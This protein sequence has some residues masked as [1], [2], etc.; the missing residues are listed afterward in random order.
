[1]KNLYFKLILILTI[2]IAFAHEYHKNKEP[3]Q[4]QWL[5]VLPGI[6]ILVL[7]QSTG[8]IHNDTPQ[9]K[10]FPLDMLKK[11]MRVVK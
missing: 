10:V 7:N 9:V 8:R 1:M 2:G 3:I 6:S 5:I 11:D 4:L